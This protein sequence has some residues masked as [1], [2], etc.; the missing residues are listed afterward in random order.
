M[1][2]NQRLFVYFDRKFSIRRR[3][4][5]GKIPYYVTKDFT[6]EIQKYYSGSLGDVEKD[7]KTEYKMKL[8]RACQ[9]EKSYSM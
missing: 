4:M 1:I 9:R 2:L 3:T 7:V 8:E 5:A 6:A